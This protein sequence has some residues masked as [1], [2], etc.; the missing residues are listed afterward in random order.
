MLILGA[1]TST[2]DGVG[3]GG[4]GNHGY[5]GYGHSGY[6]GHGG[7]GG[8]GG[9]GGHSGYGGHGGYGGYGYG[10][11]G[12]GG[13]G[14]QGYGGYGLG[15]YGGYGLGGYGGYGVGGYGGYGHDDHDDHDDFDDDVDD[16]CDDDSVPPKCLQPKAPGNCKGSLLKW[17]YNPSAR[18]CEAFLHTG[19]GGND[20]KFDT[21]SQCSNECRP[22]TCTRSTTSKK[23]SSKKHHGRKHYNPYSPYSPYHLLKKYKINQYLHNSYALG[24]KRLS[25]HVD[26]LNTPL[27][28]QYLNQYHGVQHPLTH[29]P[30]ANIYGISSHGHGSSYGGNHYYDRYSHQT[31]PAP[32]AYNGGHAQQ[33]TYQSQPQAY[34]AQPQAQ[35]QAYQAQP[36]AYQAQPQAYQAQRQAQTQAYSEPQSTLGY[37]SPTF[38]QTTHSHDQVYR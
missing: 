2:C 26:Y 18:K 3:Y 15:V 24:K 22:V 20:N 8:Y 36:Q 31:Y 19:C 7:Y 35:P 34:Q 25:V 21:E 28:Y 14:L 12:Y 37:S 29:T 10:G 9:Y 32:Q 11:L 1:L 17:W 4:F 30:F 5:G 13:Y 38:A 6:G 16:D 23:K 27:G 33:Q